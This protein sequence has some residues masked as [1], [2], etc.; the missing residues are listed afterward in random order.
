MEFVTQLWF[1]SKC[2]EVVSTVEFHVCP[3][4]GYDCISTNGR[5][6]RITLNPKDKREIIFEENKDVGAH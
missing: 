1:C 4:C 6:Y 3:R 5:K 2:R